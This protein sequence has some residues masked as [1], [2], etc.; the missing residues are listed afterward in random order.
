VYASVDAGNAIEK[1]L[2]NADGMAPV[3]RTGPA[4]DPD[5]DR[6]VATLTRAASR[7][8]APGGQRRS[9][10]V[11]EG[12]PGSTAHVPPRPSPRHRH[13]VAAGSMSRSAGAASRAVDL[14]APA[15]GAAT[16]HAGGAYH[17]RWI[18]GV[19]AW[20]IDG[21]R[22]AGGVFRRVGCRGRFPVRRA[23]LR[24][25]RSFKRH[26]AQIGLGQN[27]SSAR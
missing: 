5:G 26:R 10:T 27:D 12:A 1:A 16:R 15:G 21:A 22:G 6:V 25:R 2:G 24:H 17:S 13:G 18:D 3:H 9:T 4:A 8:A 23:S 11:A 7:C 19:A 20:I 14:D